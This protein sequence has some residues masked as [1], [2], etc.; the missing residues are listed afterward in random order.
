MSYIKAIQWKKLIRGIWETRSFASSKEQVEYQ[1]KTDQSQA[2]LL[3]V[4][5]F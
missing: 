1:I 5:Q 2:F 3:G 4:I